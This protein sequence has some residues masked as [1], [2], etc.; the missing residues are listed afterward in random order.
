VQYAPAQKPW[1]IPALGEFESSILGDDQAG[2][3]A[4][5]LGLGPLT[6]I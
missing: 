4:A 1:T 3:L 2:E 6:D 5:I